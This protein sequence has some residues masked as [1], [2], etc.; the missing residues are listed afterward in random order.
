[1]TVYLDAIWLLNFGFDFLLLKITGH[2]L[3]R[4]MVTWR[5]CIGAF[6][7][8]LIVVLMF[9]P[10]QA[11][12]ANPLLKILFSFAMILITFGFH[13]IRTFV[14]NLLVFYV[15]T[16]AIGGGML[17]I[18][19][20]L[21]VDHRFANDSIMTLTRGLGDPISWLFVLIGFP[22]LLILS[23]KQFDSIETR[24]FKYDQLATI[25]IWIEKEVITIPALVDSGNQL[26]DPITKTPVMIAEISAMQAF[27]PQELIQAVDSISQTQGWPTFS[28]D[29]KWVDRIRIVPYRA[30]GKA[31]TLMLAIK[32]DK[33][34]IIH[35]QKYVE[36]SKFLI[37][38]T[39]TNLSSE[40][41]YMCILHPK[42]L[43]GGINI[44]EAQDKA[45]VFM[46]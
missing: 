9:T 17:A 15:T 16:F 35:D 28:S 42:M 38:L 43:Q 10:L 45:N 41:D 22:I 7:G 30:V 33:A 46:V 13:R 2:I 34:I 32:P 44:G 18:H 19:F 12:V 3:K 23:K 20:A 26:L 14:E 1:M 39:K 31:T 24:K 11:L 29:T 37:G 4:Q 36:T 21:Q 40:G 8:S 5:I 6:I 27:I 25:K